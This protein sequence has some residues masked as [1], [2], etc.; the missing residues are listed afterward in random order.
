MTKEALAASLVRAFPGLP[1]GMSCGMPQT[2]RGPLDVIHGKG[3][4]LLVA[5]DRVGVAGDGSVTIPFKGEIVSRLSAWWYDRTK[6][7]VP[8]H[9]ISGGSPEELSGTGRAMIAHSANVLRLRVHVRGFLAGEAWTDYRVGRRVSGI[10]LPRGLKLNERFP[11]PLVSFISLNSMKG[12]PMTRAGALNE[13]K[14]IDELLIDAERLSRALF[15]R[16]LEISAETDLALIEARYGFG[17][18]QG[19]FVLVED[20]HGPGTARFWHAD[21]YARRFLGSQGLPELDMDI[22]PRRK[23][24]KAPASLTDEDRVA[25]TARCIKAYE[26]ITGEIFEPK[27]QDIQAEEAALARIIVERL[28]A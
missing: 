17:V 13:S 19:R 7:I 27:A 24:G 4:L 12:Q 15:R 20:L 22:L 1:E 23:G 2:R 5:S 6:D 11:Q 16:G 28:M 9:M 25:A 8:S 21:S 10:T 14:C 18:S 3:R 26:A